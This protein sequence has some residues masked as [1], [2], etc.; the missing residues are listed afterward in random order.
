MPNVIL[1]DAIILVAVE[2]N[3]GGNGQLAGNSPGYGRSFF[4][5]GAGKDAALT[6][7]AR[8]D[9]PLLG[10]RLHATGNGYAENRVLA[11][12]ACGILG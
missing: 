10:I 2:L 9:I 1:Y 12:Q 4:R 8:N 11:H 3:A 7:R 6:A 5:N